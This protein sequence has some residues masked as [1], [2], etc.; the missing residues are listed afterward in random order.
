MTDPTEIEVYP[1]GVLLDLRNL[2]RK[3]RHPGH[4]MTRWRELRA[5]ARWF[6]RSWR[7]R[8]YWN[9]YLAEVHYPPAGL[10]HR[11][12]GRGWTRRAAAR[13]LGLRLWED[14]R[15]QAGTAS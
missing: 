11:R 5:A 2:R 15:R 9:G 13:S 14:N 12:A 10:T 4:G 6:R 1:V 8:S 7:R 3:L